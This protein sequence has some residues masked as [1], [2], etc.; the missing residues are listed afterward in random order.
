MIGSEQLILLVN[1]RTLALGSH[2]NT[3][4]IDTRIN[5]VLYQ[6]RTRSPLPIQSVSE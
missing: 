2:D 1:V 6:Q 5:I 3:V 4:L